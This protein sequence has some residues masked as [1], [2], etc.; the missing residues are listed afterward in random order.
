MEAIVLLGGPGSGK[1]TAATT[2]AR[3]GEFDHISTGELFRAAMADGSTIGEAIRPF[4]DQ[5]KLVPDELVAEVVAE[6]LDGTSPT[7]KILFDGFPRTVPQA[8]SFAAYLDGAGSTLRHVFLFDVER[9][10]L[11]RRLAGRLVCSSCT[12]VYNQYSHPPKAEGC[13]DHCGSALVQRDDDREET[14]RRRLDVYDANTAP[15]IGY[16]EEL[17]LLR[18]LPADQTPETVLAAMRSKIKQGV[19]QG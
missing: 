18:R 6:V 13:C 9:D 11:I 12:A 5:G 16:Y 3:S 17:G 1:G 2:L 19:D 7:A 10:E 14:V 8:V 15:L 4:M